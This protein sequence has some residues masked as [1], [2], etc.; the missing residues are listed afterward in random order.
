MLLPQQIPAF[1]YVQFV[2]VMVGQFLKQ[3]HFLLFLVGDKLAYALT[4][5]TAHEQ[6]LL[7]NVALVFLFDD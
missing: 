7:F 4:I 6:Q 1:E 2:G 5:F 3:G